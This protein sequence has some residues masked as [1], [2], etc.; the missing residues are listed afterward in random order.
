MTAADLP[1]LRGLY[2]GTDDPWSFRSSAYEV[3]RLDAVA[4]TLPRARYAAAL[5][6]G[7]GNGELGRRIAPRCGSYTGL[8]AVP[9]A[10]AAAR[11]AMPGARLFEAFLPC[12]LPAAPG[13][14]YD[15][16]LLSEILYFL[17]AVT[18]RDLAVQIDGGH[19]G[20]DVTVA[21]WRGPTGHDLSGD[22]ALAAFAGATPR[23]WC[24]A[25]LTEGYR[26][27]FF[28]PLPQVAA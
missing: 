23:R 27:G 18:V 26:I 7:C 25:A 22:E 14:A 11:T 15:L 19:P 12:P 10:L 28:S 20:A 17:D 21:I 3:E 5:E 6:I 9:S 1:H 4:A 8:D 24:T 13:G 16:I 2:A